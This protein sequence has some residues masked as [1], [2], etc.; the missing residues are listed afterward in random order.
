MSK[1]FPLSKFSVLFLSFV[2][3]AGF[4]S[5][6]EAVELQLFYDDGSPE[7]FVF[8]PVGSCV[9]GVPTQYAICFCTDV[10]CKP[11]KLIKA[12]VYM[13]P[14]DENAPPEKLMLYV[15]SQP[16]QSEPPGTVLKEIEWYP[17]V[18][19]W[20]EITIED[21]PWFIPGERFALGVGWT[22]PETNW[23]L[24][25]DNRL[26]RPKNTWLYV[27]GSACLWT[28][29]TKENA[30]IRGIVFTSLLAKAPSRNANLTASW[31][32]VKG[33]AR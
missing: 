3:L 12:K 33:E 8:T 24:G 32:A 10:F 16:S 19:G 14:V 31:G 21:G 18:T 22:Q 13:V 30:M 20:N 1:R 25:L 4:Y 9:S 2:F 7:N 5:I 17:N 29:I 27:N 26:L 15:L 11:I 6:S 28:Y 23:L